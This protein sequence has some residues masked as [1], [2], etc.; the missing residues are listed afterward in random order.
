VNN[1]TEYAIKKFPENL[2]GVKLN[3]ANVNQQ[4]DNQILQEQQRIFN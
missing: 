2:V 4:E 3:E 1:K